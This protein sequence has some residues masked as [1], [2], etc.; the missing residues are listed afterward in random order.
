[1]KTNQNQLNEPQAYE[2]TNSKNQT[3]VKWAK[4]LNSK[5]EIRACLNNDHRL[6]MPVLALQLPQE[7]PII[8]KHRYP[9]HLCVLHIN[10]KGVIYNT[11]QIRSEKETPL[12]EISSLMLIVPE[13]FCVLYGVSADKSLIRLIQGNDFTKT[14]Q[15]KPGGIVRSM[16]A[17]EIAQIIIADKEGDGLRSK[18]PWIYVWYHNLLFVVE[19]I[20]FPSVAASSP[21]SEEIC[22]VVELLSK[23]GIDS[24]FREAVYPRIFFGKHEEITT[25]WTWWGM[26]NRLKFVRQL[27]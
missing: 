12:N 24:I 7:E 2:M 26:E 27:V 21:M 19:R 14:G 10:N 9:F 3:F 4:P 6:F 25:S 11:T 5:E 20:S 18:L 15:I 22:R 13:D 16:G 1:M 8:L 17:E 23:Q